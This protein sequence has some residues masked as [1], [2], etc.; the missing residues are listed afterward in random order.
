[1]TIKKRVVRETLL[2][3]AEGDAEVAFIRHLKSLYRDTLGR[4]VQEANAR[5]KG[6]RHVLEV[7]IRRAN[8]RDHDKVILLLDTDTDWSEAE[9]AIARRSRIPS[10][11]IPG[12][13]RRPTKVIPLSAGHH[14][15]IRVS[16]RR[17]TKTSEYA[18]KR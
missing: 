6:G 8:N 9:R 5:G 17:S 7:A 14:S 2:I 16:Q 15:K 4:A 12:F 10:A 11:P 1:M 13:R 3:V 18:R